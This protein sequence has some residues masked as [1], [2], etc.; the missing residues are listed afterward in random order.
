MPR[1]PR[2]LSVAALTAASAACYHATIETGA[3]PSAD[4]LEKSFASGWIYGLVPPS[5]VSAAARCPHGPAKVETKLSFVNQLVGLL[6]LGIY[7][8]MQIKVTC[9]AAASGAAPAAG[10]P[11]MDPVAK[12]ATPDAGE[13]APASDTVPLPPGVP[14]GTKWIAS[15][16]QKVYYPAT[17]PAA[18]SLPE[19]DRLYYATEE[20][21]RS[22]GFKRSEEC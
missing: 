10:R 7:T 3:T 16:S 1:L 8:P 5:T 17:C 11:T 20:G 15:V 14:P 4:V 9:A 19:P 18:L 6:T 22:G 21:L 13:A 2:W 12:P